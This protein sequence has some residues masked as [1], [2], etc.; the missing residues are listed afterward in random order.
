MCLGVL[1]LAMLPAASAAER[2]ALPVTIPVTGMKGNAEDHNRVSGLG[3]TVEDAGWPTLTMLTAPDGIIGTLRGPRKSANW[4]KPVSLAFGCVSIGSGGSLTDQQVNEV[5]NVITFGNAKKEVVRAT[6]SR[7][8]SAV[9]LESDSKTAELFGL[10][11]KTVDGG[12]PDTVPGPAGTVKPLRWATPDG[13]GKVL[14][15]VLGNQQV[16]E[17][18]FRDWENRFSRGESLAAEGPSRPPVDRL[19]KT[20]LL[21]WYGY[22]SPFLSTKV[23]GAVMWNSFFPG[24]NWRMN[25]AFHADVP[26]LLVFENAPQSVE[27]TEDAE[28]PRLLISFRERMGK[29]ALGPLFG[30]D[31]RAVEETEKWLAEFPDEIR[32]RCSE[33][34]ARLAE[35]PVN[36]RETVEYDSTADR[37]TFSEQFEFVTLRSGGQRM[38]PLQPMLAL[39]YQQGLPVTFSR[40][41]VDMK[42][43][44]QFGPMMGIPGE[45]YTWHMEGLG[46]YVHERPVVGPANAETAALEEELAAEVTKVIDAGHLAPW[47][48]DTRKFRFWGLYDPSETLYLLSDVSPLLPAELQGRLRQYVR[49]EY[50]QYPPHKVLRLKPREGALRDTR[51]MCT[52]GSGVPLVAYERKPSL[53]RAYGVERYHSLVGEKPTSETIDFWR[54]A[55]KESLEGRQWDTLGWFWGKYARRRPET[56]SDGAGHTS[57][58]PAQYVTN[59]R[60]RYLQITPA[61]VHRDIAGLIGY[62]RLCASAG[63]TAEAEAW[64]Q[65]AR[66]SALRF[67]MA[68]YGRYMAVSGLFQMPKDPEAAA[69]IARSGDFSKP[70]NHLQQVLEVTQHGVIVTHGVSKEFARYMARGRGYAYAP[71]CERSLIYIVPELGRLLWD[72]G[73]SDDIGRLLKRFEEIHSNWYAALS[74]LNYVGSEWA[75]M[76]PNCSHQLFMAH[77][78]IAGTGPEALQRYIDIPWTA[79]GDLYY[80]HKLGATIESSRGV[81]WGRPGK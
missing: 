13:S 63:Q 67:A 12:R 9:L 74:D 32:R 71:F 69:F 40:K 48:F 51:R 58:S 72:W 50:A 78:W 45:S 15:G 34:A 55:M 8:S 43:A 44:T 33:N 26:F 2:K 73:L 76:T 22:D 59:L 30:H 66:L 39:A 62:L 1:A 4:L 3:L 19:G 5:T 29:M 36:V 42:L 46:R 17:L 54:N 27:F 56:R 21:L 14:T 75:F 6:V 47:T 77:A 41:P 20:W 60:E 10:E 23:P 16:A 35:F 25:S 24:R 11:E 57:V 65:L 18:P 49:N 52:T 7:L 64:G 68:R 81:T 31:L 80:M 28:R 79:R 38:A 37:V 61:C 53:Y 70:E